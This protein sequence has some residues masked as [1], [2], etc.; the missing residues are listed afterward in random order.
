MS[1]TF[2]NTVS[3]VC[4]VVVTIEDT[5]QEDPETFSVLLMTSDPSVD[6]TRSSSTGIIFDDDCKS[7]LGTCMLH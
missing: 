3:E 6:I 2:T 5:F 1:R 4:L 7:P